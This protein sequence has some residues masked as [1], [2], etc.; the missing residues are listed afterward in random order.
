MF[1]NRLYLLSS[2]ADIA[3]IQVVR[4]CE[5]AFVGK[6]PTALENRL[7]ACRKRVHLNEAI[8]TSGIVGVLVPPDLAPDVPD[9]LG[10]AVCADPV[11]ALNR[12]QEQL[13]LPSS[14]Q[15]ISAPTQID[16]SA[17]IHPGAYVAPEDVVIGAQ[18]VIY[19]NAVILPRTI[20]GEG[21]TI[22][23]GTVVG[24]DAFDVDAASTPRRIIRQSGGVT[25]GRNVDIQAKCTIVRATYGGFTEIGDETKLDCQIHFAHDS[26]AGARVMIAACAEI[27]GRVVIGDDTFIG[28]NASISNGVRIGSGAHVTIGSVV[29]QDVPDG[30]RVTGNFAVDHL[31]WLKFVRSVR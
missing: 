11:S 15:W 4:D 29:T 16:P 6:V 2:F 9:E 23:A 26:R 25:I 24:T 28:P 30:R 19:P 20:I 7:V 14:G 3:G 5:L 22:G 17:I 18:V 10:L 31:S 27:S 13:A 21:S 12:V 1:S 8:Q